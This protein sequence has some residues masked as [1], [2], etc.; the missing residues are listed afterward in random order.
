MPLRPTPLAQALALALSTCTWA[1]T[2]LATD[3]AADPGAT[4]LDQVTV[5]ATL[6]PREVADTPGTVTVKEREELDREL[7][8]DI[9]DLVRYEPG[10]SVATNPGRFGLAG[11]SIR[12]IDGNRV[13]I[14]I[15]GVRIPDAF[16]IGSFSNAG[17]D[18]VDVDLLKRV[19]IIRGA[20]SS[21]YGSNAIGGVVSFQTKDPED[22][23]TPGG[24]GHLGVKGG[25]YGADDGRQGAFT[26]ALGGERVGFLLGFSHREGNEPGNQGSDDSQS[27]ARTLPNPQRYT[28]DS[29]LAKL[30]VEPADGHRLE[31]AFETGRSRT[32]TEVFTARTTSSTGPSTIQVLDLDGDD[33]QQ[34]DR[35]S[36]D[37]S[38]APATGWLDEISLQAYHQSSQ[39]RQDTVE[40]RRTSN[41]ATGAVTPQERYR[42]FH[43]DQD[44][45]GAEL[46][47]RKAFSM[48]GSEHLVVTGA[49]FIGTDFVQLRDGRARNPDTGASS[50]VIAP[51]VFP[52]RDFP[53]S[54][55]R[56]TALFIQDEITLADGALSL[57]PGLRVDRYRLD[58]RPDPIFAEDNPG[59]EPVRLSDSSV[60]PKLGA[61]WW[62]TPNWALTGQYAEGFRAPPYSDVNIG[63]TNLQ[64]GYTAIANPDLRPEESQSLELGVRGAFDW[65]R[66][67][68]T[69]Y[70]NRY[71]D[72]IE[73]LIAL[74]PTD[75]Q[76]VPGLI[77]FQSRNLTE[78]SIRG[79]ELA[80]AIDGRALTQALAGFSLRLSAA[81]ARGQDETA[82]APLASVD[83]L[84]VVTGVAYEHG[85]GWGVELIGTGVRAQTRVPQL[86]SSGYAVFDLLAWWRPR[87][88]LAVSAGVFNLADRS[89]IEWAD[90]RIAG[91]PENS[92]VRDRFTRPGRNVGLSVRLEY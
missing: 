30:V 80:A 76:A 37:Y 26:A 34:R 16:A 1:A 58:P 73:S 70:D 52:V 71:D 87:P 11:F 23:L 39:T 20:A 53:R 55:T 57:I 44:I 41:S 54:R 25:W 65:G 12:G 49:E 7:V 10:V 66:L 88:W 9:R 3:D 77:T 21:L 32:R 5:T 72:F 67:S 47:A 69:A 59:V 19:E 43:F 31:F 78:V 15:D 85:A 92:A 81:Y 17:R 36:L 38:I 27:P 84:K 8:T 14:E 29:A 61:L 40:L 62:F 86:E 64:F 56:E 18:L 63:F 48:G 60:S 75:P 82:D 13:L 33:S 83:P 46:L 4:E 35:Q 91:L 50:N 6:N 45:G 42:S 2:A 28:V 68:L 51:D 24:S 89:Y 90:A 74:D 79:A 22:Y